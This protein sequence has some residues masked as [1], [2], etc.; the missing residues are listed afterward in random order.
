MSVR[1]E[2]LHPAALPPLRRYDQHVEMTMITT[3][4][5]KSVLGLSPPMPIFQMDIRAIR[6]GKRDI[7]DNSREYA[8]NLQ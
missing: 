4:L 7:F 5:F 6:K 8:H 3:G 2:Y 1:N